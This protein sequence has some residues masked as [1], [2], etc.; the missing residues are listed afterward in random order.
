MILFDYDKATYLM[1][2]WGID[3]L[4]P[5]TLLNAGYLAD[6]WKHDLYTSIGPYTSFDKGEQYYLFVGL[7]RDHAVEPFTTCRRASEEGDMYNWDVWIQDRRVWGPSVLPRSVDSPLGQAPDRMYPDPYQAVA[8]AL[9]ERGLAEARVGIERSYLGVDAYE[10]LRALLPRASFREAGALFLELRAVKCAEEIRR[11]RIAARATQGAL[12]AAIRAIRPGMSG[13]EME[14]IGGAEHYRAGVRHEWMHTQIGPLG[15]DVVGP[16]P[17]PVRAGQ[18]MRL[19]VGASYRHYQ[20]DMSPVISLGEPSAEVTRVHRAMRR[21]MGAVLDAL[22]PG[23]SAPDLFALGNKVLQ[24]ERFESYL[25]YLGHGIGRNVHE[26]PILAADDPHL[27]EAGMTLSIEFIT[28]R[29]DIGMFGLEDNVI[30]TADGHVDLSTVG[31][32]LHVV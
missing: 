4:L 17:G 6:H 26:E 12:E 20:S 29:P 5:H 16:N 21:A 7:P 8:A 3:V 2:R 19:D 1:D 27:L 25:Q 32:Q 11:L 14:N 24:E 10:R 18:I 23:V 9:A 31:R 30:I 13:F 22:R 28:V 15:I